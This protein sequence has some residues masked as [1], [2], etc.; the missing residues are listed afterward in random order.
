MLGH[1]AAAVSTA[2]ILDASVPDVV[3]SWHAPLVTVYE[4]NPDDTYI[5]V[6]VSDP[7]YF[8]KF[9][10]INKIDE[11]ID[12][13]PGSEPYWQEK[14]GDGARIEFIGAACTLVFE[15]WQSAGALP[16]MSQVSA[17]LLMC[18]ILDNTLNFKAVVTTDRDRSAYTALSEI[19]QLP[20][21]W[22]DQ[23]FAACQQTVQA[24]VAD[25]VKFDT[26]VLS[27]TSFNKPVSFGQVA[28]WDSRMLIDSHQQTMKHELK[29]LSENW[30]MNVLDLQ[31]GASYLVS[32]VPEVQSWLTELLGVHFNGPVAKAD[33]LWLRKEILKQDLQYHG[34]PQ[35]PAR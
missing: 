15:A 20:E 33:R 35:P 27:F 30:M 8:E 7:D 4:P 9:V 1:E 21:D 28:I 13:H 5:L 32:D 25:A 24:N 34:A 3:K 17:R 19:A 29:I 18:G 22:P 23:Y 26:K 2:K 6:D 14:I 10:N 12:H 11:V 31:E 16:N